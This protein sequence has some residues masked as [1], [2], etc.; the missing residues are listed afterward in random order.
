M[1]TRY[2]VLVL[3]ALSACTQS[4]SPQQAQAPE[5]STPPPES[6]LDQRRMDVYEAAI[7]GLY[8]TEGWYDPVIID[9]RICADAASTS[10][11]GKDTCRDAF[12]DEEQQVV[13]D[14]LSDLPSVRFTSRAH[15]VRKRI[16]RG[17]GS[18]GLLSVGPI[19]GRGTGSR[20]PG[21]FTAVASAG[22]G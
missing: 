20:S 18:A 3:L 21:V 17:S 22:T 2:L 5:A 15:V 13:V 11:D 12:S 14:A 4:P 16:L 8:D 10:A 1:K 9:K 19:D 6:R 7:R